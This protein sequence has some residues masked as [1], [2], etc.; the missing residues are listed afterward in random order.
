MVRVQTTEATAKRWKALQALGV[1][2]ILVA[3]TL[4]AI[5]FAGADFN[6]RDANQQTQATILG[7]GFVGLLASLPFY[8]AGRVGAWW[9]HG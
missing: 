4:I 3:A 6:A 8:V 2:G 1:L 9:Y 7:I 5:G